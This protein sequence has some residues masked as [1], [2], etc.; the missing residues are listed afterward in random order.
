M[1]E[2]KSIE[3]YYKDFETY[4]N[5]LINER[6]NNKI[7][8]KVL[9]NDKILL[10]DYSDYLEKIYRNFNQDK[11][12]INKMINDI[13]TK[14]LLPMKLFSY[15]EKKVFVKFIC[16][17]TRDDEQRKKLKILLV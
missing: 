13:K 17:K 1:D 6:K 8:K 11:T 4:I 12:T 10:Q 15:R 7:S 5:K 16:N 14:I 9:N 2:K 3:E